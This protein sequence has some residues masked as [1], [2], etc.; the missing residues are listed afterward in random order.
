MRGYKAEVGEGLGF[1]GQDGAKK[2]GAGLARVGVTS[3]VSV[4]TPRG[5]CKLGVCLRAT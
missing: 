1:M 5:P 2:R 3:V 4:T